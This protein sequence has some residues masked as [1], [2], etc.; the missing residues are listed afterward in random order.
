[1]KK[2]FLSLLIILL[3]VFL[4]TSVA[5]AENNSCDK[6]KGSLVIVGGALESSNSDIYNK[7]I[8]LAGGKEKAKIG[9]I[10]A[11]S[12]K[13]VYYS[14]QFKNDLIKY[15]VSE[16]NIE[17][18][19]IAVKNDKTTPDVDESKWCENG[20]NKEI[21]EKLKTYTGIWF[22]GGDQT[23]IT[24]TLYNKDGSNTMAL[25]AIWQA[26]KNGAV[27]GGTSAGAAIMS[28]PMIAGGNS[29]DALNY[30]FTDK[31]E[32]MD[33][34]EYGPV[35]VTKGLGFFKDGIVDQHFDMKAR[36]GRLIVVAYGNKDKW[37]FSFG[38][39]E[40]T[41]M[42]V[43]NTDRT[44]EVVGRGGVTIVNMKKSYKEEINKK[45]YYKDVVISYIEKGDK[46]NLDTKEF[47]I[48]KCKDLTNGYEYYDLKNPI[49]TGVFNAHTR[50]KDFIT[51]D[52]VDN[53]GANEVKSYCFDSKGEGFELVFKKT[54]ET[55]GY[56]AYID[57]V[58]DHYSAVNVSVDI[59]PI[60]VKIEYEK[61]EV[62]NAKVADN[63]YIVQKGDNLWKISKKYNVELK[64]LVEKNKIKSPY[65]IFTGQRL[66]IP[67]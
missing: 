10:G 9:I 42:V 57:G 39:D 2:K 58:V 63:I 34:Q 66:V 13:P 22:V 18:V 40:N 47:E 26:Y 8:E 1:M 19:P 21:A 67:M 29:M 53:A 35:Y 15:G 54:A 20:N 28:D 41:A 3:M 65:R 14:N 43:N 64:K 25:D 37:D 16:S 23:R 31:Y 5:F 50:L 4:M 61:D 38:V 12:S 44:I 30:G 51:Y 11:A 33:Q 17:I 49:I 46:F 52:L 45:P 7:F 48:N 55:K 24:Q 6:I 56:W 32:D 36:L 62:V 60:K 59:R 27:I